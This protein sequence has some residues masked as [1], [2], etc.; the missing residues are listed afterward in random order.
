MALYLELYESLKRQII[1][2]D[3]EIDDKLPSKC[4]L[5]KHLNLS[6]TTIE[7]AYE[8]LLDEEFNYSKPRRGYYVSKLEVLPVIR[9]EI[10]EVSIQKDK[11]T[12]KYEF[13]TAQVDV[14]HF[15]F[16]MFRKLS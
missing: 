12:Y 8:L 2:R 7:R 11:N 9:K 14:E 1:S 13:K 15:P 3:Y 4:K 5:E 16:D 6:Q 10:E